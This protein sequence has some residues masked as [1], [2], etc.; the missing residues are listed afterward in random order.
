MWSIYLA[1]HLDFLLCRMLSGKNKPD[2]SFDQFRMIRERSIG[3]LLWRMKRYLDTFLEP[4]LHAAGY[5][6]FKTSYL[7][8][9]ANIDE[10]GTTNNELARRAGV[11]KQ[12]M[13]KTVSLLEREGYIYTEKN[14]SDSRSSVI[15]LN[16]RGKQLF[17]VLRETFQEA[18]TKFDVIVGHDRMEQ[19]VDTLVVLT[20]ALEKEEL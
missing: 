20:A 10:K 2:F 19:L 3:R 17:I 13:S 12:M 8:F 7:A 5:T 14:P 15:F 4:R 9:L 11:T 6:D 16:E 18:R 1:Y